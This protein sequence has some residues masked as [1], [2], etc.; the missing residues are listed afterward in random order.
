MNAIALIRATA[1][2]IVVVLIA[3]AA[4][5]LTGGSGLRAPIAETTSD[6]NGADRAA[7]GNANGASACDAT[8]IDAHNFSR[9]DLQLK[10]DFVTPSYP[11]AVSDNDSK[12]ICNITS[13]ADAVLGDIAGGGYWSVTVTNSG[14]TRTGL[15]T[16]T[17]K[18]K[19]A[20]AQFG[21][22]GVARATLT[23]AKYNTEH[24]PLV[25]STDWRTILNNSS[26]FLALP[27]N[28]MAAPDASSR[29][30]GAVQSGAVVKVKSF[31][32]SQWRKVVFQT[33]HGDEEGYMP[34]RALKPYS[35]LRPAPE[36][37]WGFVPVLAFP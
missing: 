6:P 35:P 23:N 37:T 18:M 27:A 5:Q 1:L 9:N 4:W 2:L 12:V 22:K 25:A 8:N 21:L 19:L 34:V 26:A 32:N 10:E 20:N 3:G 33:A 24:L 28:L 13:P 16:D 11:L 29:V 31:D 30:I 7:P 14:Q 15:I 17:E 36:G